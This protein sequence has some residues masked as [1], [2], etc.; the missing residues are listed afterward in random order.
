MDW[1]QVFLL[2]PLRLVRILCSH[3][4]KS[5]FDQVVDLGEHDNSEIKRAVL[6]H[7]E[8]KYERALR[9]YDQLVPICVNS[10]LIM[11]DT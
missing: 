4:M 5:H 7:T 11:I 9:I 6:P 8:L 10:T 2:K 3:N 1:L